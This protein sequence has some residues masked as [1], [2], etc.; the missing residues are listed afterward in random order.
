M[1]LGSLWH[2]VLMLMM[3]QKKIATARS[4]V[5]GFERVTL[6]LDKVLAVVLE[7]PQPLK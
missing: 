4:V 5:P 3:L 7:A 2:H 1:T 6:N